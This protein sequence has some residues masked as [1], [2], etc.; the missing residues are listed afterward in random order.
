MTSFEP[1]ACGLAASWA[2]H[3]LL[4]DTVTVFPLLVSCSVIT[5]PGVSKSTSM[6]S[7]LS[8]DSASSDSMSEEP[9]M[10]LEPVSVSSFGF[11]V[12][13]FDWALGIELWGFSWDFSSDKFTYLALSVSLMF[14]FVFSDI[15]W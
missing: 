12:L 6:N 11:W 5:G 1:L 13:G 9:P 14:L 7:W 15:A 4:S 2:G 3:M 8:C 10:S